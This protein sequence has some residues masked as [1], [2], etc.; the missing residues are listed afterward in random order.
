MKCEVPIRSGLLEHRGSWAVD[1]EYFRYQ[2]LEESRL[3]HVE[4]PD[5]RKDRDRLSERDTR[6]RIVSTRKMQRRKV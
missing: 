6:E 2:E 3:A 4:T 5:M 1:L